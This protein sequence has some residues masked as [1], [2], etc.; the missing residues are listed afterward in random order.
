MWVSGS[1]YKRR[2]DLVGFVNSLL[3]IFIELKKSHGTIEHAYRHNLKDNKKTVP[4]LFCYN[5]PIILPNGAQAK[6]GSMTAGWEHF[7]DWK[8]INAEDETGVIS[9]ETLIR[10]VCEKNRLMDLV[11]NFT[12]FEDA[13]GGL[14][15]ITVKNHQFLGVNNAVDGAMSSKRS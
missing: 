10:G 5:A 3:L 15:K 1:V 14:V 7:A 2:A 12:L 9:L 4:Q 11:E 13:K 8:R 6:V